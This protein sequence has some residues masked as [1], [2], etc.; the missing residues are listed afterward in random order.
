MRLEGIAADVIRAPVW[1]LK[2]RGSGRTQYSWPRPGFGAFGQKR[3]SAKLKSA[4]TERTQ[5][6]H[7][8]LLAITSLARETK[9]TCTLE[10]GDLMDALAK[11][12]ELYD[13]KKT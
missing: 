11:L 2:S 3:T 6:C 4:S 5:T 7:A 8:W 10:R 9:Q 1:E 13:L 12:Q